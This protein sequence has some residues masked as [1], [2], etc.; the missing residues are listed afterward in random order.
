MNNLNVFY[1][2]NSN[3]NLND[4]Y[5]SCHE[6]LYLNFVCNIFQIQNTLLLILC[7]HYYF[8]SINYKRHMFITRS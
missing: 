1:D 7:M 6:I 5:V 3:T 2:G 8:R 4:Q